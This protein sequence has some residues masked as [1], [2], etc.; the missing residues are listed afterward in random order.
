MKLPCLP[1]LAFAVAA[2]LGLSFAPLHAGEPSAEKV[3]LAP[4]ASARPAVMWMWMGSNITPSGITNDLEKLRDAGFGGTL[5]FS[6]ADVCTP[7]A[8]DI[9][10]APH[11]EVVAFTPPWWKLVR[12]AASESLRLGLDFGIGNC[13]GYESSGGPWITPEL[14]MQEVVWS[15]TRV[16]GGAAFT[17]VLPLPAPDP[18]ANQMFPVWNP[19]NGKLEKPEVPARLSFF[20]DIAVLALPATGPVAPD[21]IIDLSARLS[22]DDRLDWTAPAG[23]WIVYRFGHTTKGKLIQ[24]SQWKAIGL[25]CDKLDRAAVEFHLDHISQEARTHLGDLI[26]TGF[27]FF[28]FDSYE[29]GTPGWTARMREEF[30]TRR[31]YDPVPFLPTLAKRVIGDKARSDAYRADFARTIADLFRE[32]YYPVIERKLRAAGI[33]YSCEPYGGPWKISEIAPHVDRLMAEFWT[34]AEKPKFNGHLNETVRVGLETGFNPIS[35]EAFTGSPANSLWNETPA[36]IKAMGDGAFAL[37]INRFVLHRFTHQPWGD[38]H[39]PGVMMGQWGTHFDHTQTWWEPGKAWV[40]YITRCQA[41]LQWGKAVL[42]PDSAAKF[43]VTSGEPELRSFRRSDG[44]TDVFFVANI[45]RSAGTATARFPLDDR[46]PELWHPVTGEMRP[47]PGYSVSAGAI[48]VPLTFDDSESVF[49]VFRPALFARPKSSTAANYPALAP[50]L[51]LAGARWSVAFDPKWGGPASTTFNSLTDWKDHTDVGIKYYSGTATYS[52]TFTAPAT[53]ASDAR[54]RS[55]RVWLDLGVVKDLARV[56]L[57]GRDLGVVWT[58]P[59]RVEITDVLRSGENQLEI[60]VTNT[61]VNRLIGDEQL[62]ADCE[63][64]KGDRGHGGPL[65][66]YPDWVLDNTPRPSPGRFTFTTWNY[67]TAKSPLLSSGLLGPVNVLV[68]PTQP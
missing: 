63:W 23:D 57:N 44:K 12:H 29:A 31:G 32:N 37:G 48:E 39:K 34:Y 38:L 55:S 42:P 62:P 56:R 45:A 24:P 5:V 54:S 47:L 4:P 64:N 10:K 46:R 22:A 51:S 60:A 20:R 19:E 33:E 59:W 36:S 8:R 9:A 40:S 2:A 27:K 14:S 26:G 15:E 3:F 17:G 58:A 49:I 28:H 18:H 16:S 6:L 13:A 68:S 21:Q 66:V 7:W 1:R 41:L 61:W 43:T 65:K 30:R 52:T 35:A 25:E 67:F 53:L 50:A 11:P